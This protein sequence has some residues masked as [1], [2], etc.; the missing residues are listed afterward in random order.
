MNT[1]TLVNLVSATAKI[2]LNMSGVSGKLEERLRLTNSFNKRI[3]VHPDTPDR[4]IEGING[5]HA[6]TRTT[7]RSRFT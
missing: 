2:K 1:K 7:N 6:Y 5:Q 3:S 4:I